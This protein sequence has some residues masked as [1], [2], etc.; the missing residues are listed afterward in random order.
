MYWKIRTPAN[1]LTRSAPRMSR[2]ASTNDGTLRMTN[3]NTV[4]TRSLSR[5]WRTA[6]Q[7]PT[8]TPI[9]VPST[10]P[11]TTSRRLTPIRRHSSW[12]TG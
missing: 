10:E 11:I 6:P 5:Y 8:M 2:L 7:A 4:I 1:M 9:T 3:D 12:E